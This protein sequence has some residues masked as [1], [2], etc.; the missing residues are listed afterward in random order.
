MRSTKHYVFRAVPMIALIC[1]TSCRPDYF[2]ETPTTFPLKDIYEQISSQ[3]K[4]ANQSFRLLADSLQNGWNKTEGSTTVDSL[5]LQEADVTFDNVVSS[6]VGGSLL[7][8]FVKPG[9]TYSTKNETT[10]KFSLIKAVPKTVKGEKGRNE[11]PRDQNALSKLICS[12]AIQFSQDSTGTSLATDLEKHLEINIAFSV[13]Q[14]G[15]V[16]LSIPFGSITPD[17]NGSKEFVNTNT[18]ALKFLLKKTK[19][20]G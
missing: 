16:D 6:T 2:V 3:F 9:Y 20:Q 10:V 8:V 12:A 13:D 15:S 18:I 5:L 14:K 7:I 11:P 17:I 1:L 19:K 4:I